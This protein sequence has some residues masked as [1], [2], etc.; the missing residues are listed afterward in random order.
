M[1][2]PP[3]FTLDGH[4]E[5]ANNL[6]GVAR[7]FYGFVTQQAEAGGTQSFY[8]SVT[9][10]DGSIIRAITYKNPITKNRSGHIT[11]IAPPPPV[12]AE[13]ERT[14]FYPFATCDYVNTNVA[15]VPKSHIF[16]TT[17]LDTLT[18]EA[19]E[20]GS[21]FEERFAGLYYEVLESTIYTVEDFFNYTQ[22][23]SE[24]NNLDLTPVE[25]ICNSWNLDED[26][27]VIHFMGARDYYTKFAT[28]PLIAPKPQG[29]IA[30]KRK[31]YLT[32]YTD[33]V[34]DARVSAGLMYVTH[35]FLAS[36]GQV[37]FA[38]ADVEAASDLPSYTYITN[39][40][41]VSIS[42]DNLWIGDTSYAFQASGGTKYIF[43]MKINLDCT[44]LSLLAAQL[45]YVSGEPIFHLMDFKIP[46]TINTETGDP[47]K[48]YVVLGTPVLTR[49]NNEGL[50]FKITKDNK[51]TT[52]VATD[53]T[54]YVIYLGDI[55]TNPVEW[56]GTLTERTY[57]AQY[58]E[59]LELINS[60]LKLGYWYDDK[61]GSTNYGDRNFIY[62]GVKSI[63]PKIE[64]KETIDHVSYSFPG[65]PDTSWRASKQAV[66]DDINSKC[67]GNPSTLN[68]VIS[69]AGE[70][71][72]YIFYGTSFATSTPLGMAA[73][74]YTAVTGN[75][76]YHQMVEYECI[77]G[78]SDYTIRRVKLK[79]YEEH[80]FPTLANIESYSTDKLGYHFMNPSEYQPREEF[81]LYS[82]DFQYNVNRQANMT[83]PLS[84]FPPIS[85]SGH[86]NE[87]VGYKQYHYTVLD[88]KRMDSGTETN[89]YQNVI[90]KSDDEPKIVDV[91][92][93]TPYHVMSYPPTGD[94]T[95][96]NYT[97]QPL[98]GWLPT[99]SFKY[100]ISPNRYLCGSFSYFAPQNE[101][102]LEDLSK[103]K[104]EDIYL[105]YTQFGWLY[106]NQ[107]S[108]LV[109]G[110]RK[111][112][113]KRLV[114]GLSH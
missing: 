77:S 20:L 55:P 69:T 39:I 37:K 19:L 45:V 76:T 17:G 84:V 74:G 34:L 11:I 26:G 73:P 8:R 92:T 67:V 24:T 38:V 52:P 32:G 114:W 64:Y 100:Q 44:E 22:P 35:G 1:N 63:S 30:H 101:L 104:K 21:Y 111:T 109:E 96:T 4:K 110:D 10:D 72:P 23:V 43:D 33:L 12:V 15:T 46:I 61:I 102:W 27:E 81:S 90:L 58:T 14:G 50:T 79:H 3:S 89:H 65:I 56:N 75:Y 103:V 66:V 36:N 108:A 59:T 7:Q 91:T 48:Y 18:L 82:R 29:F 6:K 16:S 68:G 70:F 83:L 9:L 97:F 71:Q 41:T 85:G 88:R 31:R 57:Q 5:S 40:V 28:I 2:I 113:A 80:P 87:A 42:G 99:N 13:E 95:T 78:G 49:Y 93:H 47:L 112:N 54:D 86:F 107:D 94:N 51:I 25:K 60:S 98:N 62:Y 53:T 106:I 105:L